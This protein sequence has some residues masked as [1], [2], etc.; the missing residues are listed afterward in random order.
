MEQGGNFSDS[1]PAVLGDREYPRAP[2]TIDSII[3]QVRGIINKVALSIECMLALIASAG[4]LVIIASVRASLTDRLY[5]SAVVRALGA[6]QQVIVTA[7]AI[8][9]IVLGLL[10]G[11]L[12]AFVSQ[13][14]VIALQLLV[15]SAPITLYGWVF[16][17]GMG[18]AV[19]IIAGTGL[20]AA[21]HVIQQPP[22]ALMQ[23]LL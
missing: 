22:K 9:F 6:S 7:L 4:L 13:L 14:V 12:A 21:R 1:F 5:Q 17:L 23:A 2:Q 20:W 10:A 8:E 11:L 16:L 3:Q 18:L 15:F 19:V